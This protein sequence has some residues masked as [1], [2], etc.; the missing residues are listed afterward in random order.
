MKKILPIVLICAFLSGFGQSARRSNLYGFQKY[1]PKEIIIGLQQDYYKGNSIE[2]VDQA[3]NVLVTQ[4][5]IYKCSREE[6]IFNMNSFNEV[7]ET[8]E[9]YTANVS[10]LQD[11]G[12]FLVVVQPDKD[13][14]MR[15]FVYDS[16]VY[17]KIADASLKMF[18]FQRASTEITDEYS[19]VTNYNN[20][21]GDFFS[22][23]LGHPDT[24]VTIHSSAASNELPAGS[25]ISVAKGWYDDG[26]YSKNVVCAGTSVYPLLLSF[27]DNRA[28]HEQQRLI[29]PE[30]FD[31]IPD[32]LNEVKWELDWL[33]SMQD[34]TDGGVYSKVTSMQDPVFV[35]PCDDTAE[36]FVLQ[37]TTAA[38]LNMTAVCAKAS[39]V[40]KEFLPDFA[41]EC[42]QAAKKAYEWAE[43][44]PNEYF[45]QP[46]GF[47]TK[48]YADTDMSDEFFWAGA[49]LAIATGDAQYVKNV[50]SVNEFVIP[51]WNTP[52]M[53]G[54][55]SMQNS[56]NVLTKEEK[57]VWLTK[58]QAL[59]DQCID[60]GA[61]GLYGAVQP[62]FREGSS[63]YV[64]MQG[65]LYSK[66]YKLT[67]IG[68]YNYASYQVFDFLLGKN[69]DYVYC[70]MSLNRNSELF[71]M[72]SLTGS[73]S[74]NNIGFIESGPVMSDYPQTYHDSLAGRI[75]SYF[76]TG[77]DDYSVTAKISVMWNAPFVYLA[78]Y[79]D[80][81]AFDE[82]KKIPVSKS[83]YKNADFES[84]T[85]N[86]IISLSEGVHGEVLPEDFLLIA[87]SIEYAVQEL[88]NNL[89]NDSEIILHFSEKLPEYFDDISIKY[90]GEGLFYYD[91]P[92]DSF[93][94]PVDIGN[95]L[96][97]DDFLCHKE[98]S[99]IEFFFSDKIE[100]VDINKI[101]IKEFDPIESYRYNK[102]STGF[103]ISAVIESHQALTLKV[104]SGAI[105][106]PCSRRFPIAIEYEGIISN[107]SSIFRYN[108]YDFINVESDSI[109]RI[110]FS[111]NR[112]E[113]YE[114]PFLDFSLSGG[115]E[116]IPYNFTKSSNGNVTLYFDTV[117]D[118]GDT[119]FVR[120]EGKA[121]DYDEKPFPLFDT[122]VI[123]KPIYELWWYDTVDVLT[124]KTAR[125]KYFTGRE[126][127]K[128][129]YVNVEQSGYYELGAYLKNNYENVVRPDLIRKESCYLNTTADDNNSLSKLNFY[130][131]FVD[132]GFVYDTVYLE[133]GIYIMSF[134]FDTYIYQLGVVNVKHVEYI[135]EEIKG[136]EESKDY[137]LYPNVIYAKEPL[138][139]QGIDEEGSYS[140][141]SSHGVIVQKGILNEGLVQVEGLKSGIYTIII[142][143]GQDAIEE[144]I[145]VI[146]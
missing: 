103:L 102:D 81:N 47:A 40:Y 49:E 95:Y 77:T 41:N 24:E 53:F 51:E 127:T 45:V 113:F 46:D 135:P 121:L 35:K 128:M 67:G 144:K 36:R 115:T 109:T 8:M 92:V 64:A 17:A 74:K 10:A 125:I 123:Y 44:N 126:N 73:T 28:Y 114:F 78:S 106:S 52:A 1:Q 139:I 63:G 142:T 59:A 111:T 129:A 22:R 27:E 29:I 131:Q 96:W 4:K 72:K 100:I 71:D 62:T 118:D 6:E 39:V 91:E 85:D 130:D 30:S 48:E 68:K 38:S 75:G 19:Y 66:L 99:E 82:H 105:V 43:Q 2:I 32:I 20:R 34:P 42:L 141:V 5:L 86:I 110:R 84:D 54:L 15:L 21:Y 146:E 16:N 108:I 98:S 107:Y 11:V 137:S 120:N 50:T 56:E 3:G 65:L 133:K 33:L 87:D 80:N 134:N 55:L 116:I 58:L 140:I 9:Y 89:E 83:I 101:S 97:F 122:C 31:T 60:K 136:V 23:A 57:Q 90:N 13:T 26:M 79:V 70:E 93:D 124:D 143:T 132:K 112:L 61:T 94:I 76:N 18:Y 119:I 104:D 14:I 117:L 145:M 69:L 88:E 138:H 25:K 12:N 37:K 7:I